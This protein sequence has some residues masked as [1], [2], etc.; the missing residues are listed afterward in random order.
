MPSVPQFFTRLYRSRRIIATMAVQEIRDRYLGTAAGIIWSVIN[1]LSMIVIYTFVF[2]KMLRSQPVG[3]V[4]YLVYFCCGLFPWLTFSETLL[5]GTNTITSHAYMAKKMVFPTE[6]LP[7]VTVAANLIT[8]GI[9]LAILILILIG[10]GIGLSFWN[11]EVFYY[12]TAMT[13]L[14]VGVC[15]LV[16]A[17][18]VFFRDTNMI[19]GVIVNIWLWVTPIIWFTDWLPPGYAKWIWLNPMYYIV[20]GYRLAFVHHQ[21]FW[22]NFGVGLYFWT[23]AALF[24]VLGGA[25][26]RRLKP[27]FAEAL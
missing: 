26:F 27:D 11:L 13:V 24:F 20:D 10:N 4:P 23:V 22:H 21:P 9:L 2:T 8:H 7:I 18:S 17:I 5:A 15:W 19:M 3:D 6:I 16:S 1:P 25:V 12:L 14:L